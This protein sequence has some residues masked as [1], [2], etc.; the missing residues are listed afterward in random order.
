M[1]MRLLGMNTIKSP[2]RFGTIRETF[3]K[4]DAEDLNP[5]LLQ[6]FAKRFPQGEQIAATVELDSPVQVFEVTAN[7]GDSLTLNHD[8]FKKP[9]TLSIKEKPDVFKR[10]LAFLLPVINGNP[11]SAQEWWTRSFRR[12]I[13]EVYKVNPPYLRLSDLDDPKK[14][15]N[16]FGFSLNGHIFLLRN[17]NFDLQGQP[18]IN[19]IQG[20]PQRVKEMFLALLPAKLRKNYQKDEKNGGNAV[21]EAIGD[22]LKTAF[23]QHLYPIYSEGEYEKASFLCNLP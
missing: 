2:L 22:R 7:S 14:L 12:R 19:P 10:L 15:Y 18:S 8:V 5:K 11:S 23:P 17:K 6:A 1:S 21:I 20:N 9:V 13:N 3:K 16:P 4:E